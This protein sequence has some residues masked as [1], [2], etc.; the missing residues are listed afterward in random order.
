MIG[1]WHSKGL[2]FDPNR[3]YICRWGHA[4]LRFVAVFRLARG[5]FRDAPAVVLALGAALSEDDNSSWDCFGV[6]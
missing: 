6:R 2:L 5:F 3:T 1:F 4:I